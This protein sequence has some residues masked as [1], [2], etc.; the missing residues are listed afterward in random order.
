LV[1]AEGE[2]AR[3]QSAQHVFVHLSAVPVAVLLETGAH[4]VVAAS[5]V[6]AAKAASFHTLR[7]GRIVAHLTN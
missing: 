1:G 3:I 2:D 4:A 6:A 5:L 7:M